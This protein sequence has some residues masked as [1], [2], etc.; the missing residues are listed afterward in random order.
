MGF[1]N[2]DRARP[3]RDNGYSACRVGRWDCGFPDRPTGEICERYDMP[4]FSPEGLEWLLVPAVLVACAMAF[5]I[6]AN[7]SANSWGTSVGSNAIS[8]RN[9][10]LLGGFSEWLGASLLGYGVSGT[11]R[12]GVAPIDDPN[13]WACG[14]CDS[15]M[16]V[17]AVAMLAALIG[18][19]L[20]LALATFTS[21]PVS[22]THAIVGGVV[23]A[24]V[25]ATPASCLNWGLDGEP[26]VPSNEFQG[27]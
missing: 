22:T 17:N 13:C 2:P 6:G 4:Y 19:A 20:F 26:P 9:A 8:L 11:I 23:G 3:A 18:A 1:I 7:D 10:V 12:H 21:M 27:G 25:V 24:T 14:Y 16:A 15:K 5:G